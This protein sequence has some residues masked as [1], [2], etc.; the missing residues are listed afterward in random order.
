MKNFLCA[1]S[2]LLGSILAVFLL[3]AC[4]TPP[5]GGEAKMAEFDQVNDPF[6]PVNR[7][8][9]SFNQ[10]V[11]GVLFEPLAM[12]YRDLLP[13]PVRDSVENFL[14]NLR[15]PVTLASDLA[16]GKMDR[17]TTTVG[18]FVINSTI[19]VGGLI[20][21]AEEFGLEG[22]REDFGQTLA[23]WGSE[24][25]LYLVLPLFGPSNV[26][27]AV[28]L[29]ADAFLDPLTYFASTQALVARTFVRGIDERENVLDTL[30]EIERTSIDYYA[31][32]R[33]LYRQRRADEI[34][35]GEPA[36]VIPIPSISIDDFESDK[37]G[38]ATLV[39]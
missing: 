5:L 37:S 21:M 17:A 20:D 23:V 26:R 28:G 33:S 13:P 34:R 9:F 39:N 24:E 22:H 10:F 25:G 19:G 35:D 36:P 11:D 6:E 31:T 8:I 12:L 30:D 15:S 27:D 32:L 3:A 7:G 38:Q 14:N 4:A 16:Q 18:R 1:R 29:V 2:R